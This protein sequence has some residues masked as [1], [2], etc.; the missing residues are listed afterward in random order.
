MESVHPGVSS[1]GRVC[2]LK[3]QAS[4]FKCHLGKSKNNASLNLH[5]KEDFRNSTF[6]SLS[7][8]SKDLLGSTSD[9]IS[10]KFRH[11]EFKMCP[12]V[13]NVMR[14]WFFNEQHGMLG[15]CIVT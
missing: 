5:K 15:S 1:G 13:R 8:N 3:S 2:K 12:N 6:H 7:S 10:S 14:E 4:S 11:L 9:L